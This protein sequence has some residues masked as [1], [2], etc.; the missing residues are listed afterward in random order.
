MAITK[1]KK[2]SIVSSFS[3]ILKNASSVVFVKFDKLTVK[4]ANEFRRKLRAS[5]VGYKVGKKTLLK[6]VLD[7]QGYTGT[8]PDLKGEVGIAYS[9]D[10]LAPA[11]EVYEFQKSNKEFVDMLG[12]M[13]DGQ[14]KDKAAMLSMANIPSLH[15][16]RGMFVNVINSPVQRFVI[17]LDAIAKKK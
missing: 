2:Q 9:N 16:L 10:L 17:A 15:T 13:F 1:S 11:R 4:S 7:S 6:R 3:D 5:G 12:G 14:Y 8:M